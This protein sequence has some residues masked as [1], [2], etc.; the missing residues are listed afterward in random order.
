MDLQQH[1]TLHVKRRDVVLAGCKTTPVTPVDD[2]A[3]KAVTVDCYG[4]MP[5]HEVAGGAV[6]A[7]TAAAAHQQGLWDVCLRHRLQ[8]GHARQAAQ[9]GRL[10]APLH[11]PDALALQQARGGRRGN[12][13]WNKMVDI[14]G[15]TPTS[16]TPAVLY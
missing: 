7:A 8:C 10:T 11:Q 2:K 9:H 15:Q 4:A 14:A 12:V 6:A 3:G 16:I 1:S 13:Q 5:C